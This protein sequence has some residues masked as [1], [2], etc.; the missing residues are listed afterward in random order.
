M[1]FKFKRKHLKSYRFLKSLKKQENQFFTVDIDAIPVKNRTTVIEAL[2][3]FKQTG[4][5]S[6]RKDLKIEK[7]IDSFSFSSEIIE[8][9]IVIFC[10][11]K[12][13]E[14]MFEELQKVFPN[15]ISANFNEESKRLVRSKTLTYAGKNFFFVEYTDMEIFFKEMYK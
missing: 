4:V 12:L 5:L 14:D 15:N 13:V 3:I 10:D 1:G 9:P 6:F 8:K 2:N 11:L 7:L